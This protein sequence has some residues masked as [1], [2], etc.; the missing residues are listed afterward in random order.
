LQPRPLAQR[1]RG[2]LEHSPSFSRTIAARRQRTGTL[3]RHSAAMSVC[4]VVAGAP[5]ADDLLGALLRDRSPSRRY[6]AIKGA[7][8]AGRTIPSCGATSRLPQRAGFVGPPD[9]SPWPRTWAQAISGSARPPLQ[10]GGSIRPQGA[11]MPVGARLEWDCTDL[12]RAENAAPTR[13]EAQLPGSN[14]GSSPRSAAPG[15][16]PGEGGLVFSGSAA[17]PERIG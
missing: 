17:E 5:P 13:I 7:A 11:A 12:A 6:P 1:S 3:S 2:G 10:P 4:P 9:E 15:S 8:S 16:G 14:S